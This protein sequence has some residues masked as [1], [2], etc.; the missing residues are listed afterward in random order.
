MIRTLYIQNYALIESLN[1]TFEDGFSVITGETGAGKSIMLGAL[2]LLLGQ[3]ADSKAIRQ[4]ASK[5]VIEAHFDVKDYHLQLFFQTIGVDY[6]DDCIL[7]REVYSS[8]KSRAFINDTPV[9][10]SQMKELGD[11]L[12]DIHSQHQNLMLNDEGFQLDVLDILSHHHKQLAEYKA[13]YKSWMDDKKALNKLME[14]AERNKA[15]EDYVRFQLT[16][17]QEARLQADE[18]ESLEQEQDMLSHAED[19]KSALYHSAQLLDG[20]EQSLLQSLKDC[21]SSLASIS[22]VFPSADVLAERLNSSYIELKDIAEELIS[23]EESVE[24]NPSRLDEVAERL[25][26]IYT[27]QKKHHV[28]TIAELMAIE[29]DYQKRLDSITSSDDQIDALRLR[30][31]QKQQELLKEASVLTSN[32]KQAAKEVEA[33]MQSRLVALGMPNAHFHIEVNPRKEPDLNGMDSVRFLFSANKNGVLQDI[34]FVASGGEVARVMLSLKALL[35]GETRLS[36]IIFDEIDTGVSGEIASRMADMMQDMANGNSNETHQ[37]G[38]QVISITHLPQIAAK[39]TVHYKVYKK[40]N[41]HE[42][43]SHIRRLTSEERI[44][45][46]AKMLSGESVTDAALQNARELLKIRN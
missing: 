16:Q 19:I 43:V 17:L 34:S 30:C 14:E 46:I 2:A 5:C 42:T 39:G 18:Q 20:D 4:G 33:K 23:Q 28:N 15:D 29:A 7:R 1:I 40:D 27:L 12:I 9:Q 45:E 44:E 24:F 31:Q 13:I 32:R 38:R 21:R 3:R 26:T 25:N 41:E 6:D 35:A 8:G 22:K 11:K 10:L 36:T 37:V